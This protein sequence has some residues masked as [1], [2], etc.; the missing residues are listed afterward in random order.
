M[1]IVFV[2]GRRFVICM[3]EQ[4]QEYLYTLGTYLKCKHNVF[5]ATDKLNTKKERLIEQL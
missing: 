5:C 4:E 1:G 3:L 2:D